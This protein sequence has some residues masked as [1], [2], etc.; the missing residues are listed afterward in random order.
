MSIGIKST[1]ETDGILITAR[2]TSTTKGA[3]STIMTESCLD[4]TKSRIWSRTRVAKHAFQFQEHAHP[5]KTEQQ[6]A[7]AEA[8]AALQKRA[9]GQLIEL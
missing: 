9:P 4:L 5:I 3:A 8:K 2:L 7:L 6:L 1:I